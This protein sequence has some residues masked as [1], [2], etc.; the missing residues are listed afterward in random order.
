MAFE[1][2][3]IAYNF[4][5]LSG[6][7]KR[8]SL[9]N[10]LGQWVV[11]YFYLRDNTPGCTTEACGFRDELGNI[12]EFGAVVLGI[13]PDSPEKHSEF[14][15]KYDL[16][17]ELLSDPNHIIADKYGVWTERKRFGK[18]YWGIKRSTFLINPEGKIVHRWLKVRPE[19]HPAQ[20]MD[21]LAELASE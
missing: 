12:A 21:K 17:F 9:N 6:S 20:V 11:L 4:T 18:S 8:V 16:N 1:S 5:L 14:I 19:E 10:Y 7:G 15:E 2:D 13:S 3:D